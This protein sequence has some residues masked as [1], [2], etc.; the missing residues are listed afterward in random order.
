[1][2]PLAFCNGRARIVNICGGSGFLRKLYSMGLLPGEIITVI[3]NMGGPI[4]VE[5]RGARVAIG[6]GMA[7]KIY[8]EPV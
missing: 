1:M 3:N 4:L 7:M 8:V 2:I 6:R 5:V